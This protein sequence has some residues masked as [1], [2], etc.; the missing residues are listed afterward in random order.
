LLLLEQEQEWEREQEG[1][2]EQ[3]Q[4]LFL[5]KVSALNEEDW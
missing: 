3:E 1:D 4:L 2:L 5:D